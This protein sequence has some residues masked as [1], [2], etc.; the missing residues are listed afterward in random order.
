MGH[1]P[2]YTS[3]YQSM[4][5]R[6]PNT[7]LR[8]ACFAAMAIGV[9]AI[10]YGILVPGTEVS[11]GAHE[12]H[13]R[14]KG[15]FI[16]NFMYFNGIAQG[17]FMMTVIGVTTYARWTRRFKR[18][19]E[20]LAWFLPISYALLLI[21]LAAGGIEVFPWHHQGADGLHAAGAH[22]KAIYFDTSF[23]WARQIIGL[24]FMT[25]LSIWFI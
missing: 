7:K 4:A 5:D 1:A 22:H 19:H 24:G 10:T 13:L 9:A 15:A 23:F 16:Q 11:F 2:D 6:K 20:A 14:V 12:H 21:F 17:G 3:V 18:V 8:N 25:F